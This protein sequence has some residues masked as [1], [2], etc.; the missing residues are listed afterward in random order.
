MNFELRDVNCE[1]KM[2]RNHIS[3]SSEIKNKQEPPS[4]A[5]LKPSDESLDNWK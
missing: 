2:L 5:K 3:V 4:I 1:Q